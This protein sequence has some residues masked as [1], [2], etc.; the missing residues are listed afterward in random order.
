MKQPYPEENGKIKIKD[1]QMEWRMRRSKGES[2]FGIRGS[3]IFELTIIKD[4]KK[5]LEYER[6]Y[7]KK[8]AE[9]D[10]E[11]AL[12]LSFLIDRYG[13]VKKKERKA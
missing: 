7:S 4:G 10:E 8:P 2:V 13:K 1:C 12:C 3:R 11:T 9:E 5:T 6:G